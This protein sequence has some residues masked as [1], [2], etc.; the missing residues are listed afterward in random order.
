M[1][2]LVIQFD[3]YNWETVHDI[4]RCKTEQE[5]IAL[6]ESIDPEFMY[7][8][9]VNLKFDKEGN[10]NRESIKGLNNLFEEYREVISS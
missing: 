5:A 8:Q 1:I 7:T 10:S 2:Y 6:R 9:Q 4:Y 3:N